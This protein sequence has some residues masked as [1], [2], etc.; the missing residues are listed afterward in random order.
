M[1]NLDT[2]DLDA[3]DGRTIKV[4]NWA[5]HE[6][7]PIG[8]V[9]VLHGLGEHARRY[10]HFA[11]TCIGHNLA[12]VSHNHRGHGVALWTV[13]TMRMTTSYARGNFWPTC[14]HWSGYLA[15]PQYGV[16]HCPEFRHA[17]RREQRRIDSAGL[18]AGN[19][20]R[21]LHQPFV[22]SAFAAMADKRSRSEFLTQ[23][24]LDDFNRDEVTADI[25]A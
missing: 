9:Q 15:W 24:D 16:I 12:A 14:I 11:S 6:R 19:P 5:P 21:A 10:D 3:G 4:L 23:A 20:N 17:K 25:I 7:K 18:N 13:A 1:T 2:V 8:V 22:S